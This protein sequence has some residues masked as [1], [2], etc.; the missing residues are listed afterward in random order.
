MEK[1]KNYED[2]KADYEEY[3]YINKISDRYYPQKSLNEKQILRYYSQYV[4]KWK[5]AYSE[6]FLQDDKEQS[7]DSKLSAFVRER[8]DGCRLLKLLSA[9]ELAEWQKNQNGLGGIF[10]AAHIFG[11]NAFPW[12]RFDKKNVVTLNRFS[13]NCLD[14]GK[15]PINGKTITHEQ[16]KLWWKKIAG[17]DWEYLSLL[18]SQVNGN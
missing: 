18:A 3:H 4:E 8:D 11:K 1:F 5:R 7:D 13:H 2:F 15:S 14:N 6:R 16:R 17:E 10:D 9:D 12:M